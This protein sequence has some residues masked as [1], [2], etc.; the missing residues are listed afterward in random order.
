MNKYELTVVLN[1]K[2]E[3]EERAAAMEKINGY[4]TRFGGTVTGV[5]EWGKKRLAYEIQKMKEGFYY[6]I[7]FDGAST[8]P[9]DLEENVRIMEPVIRYLCVKQEA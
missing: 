8:T 9:N 1:A 3:D 4:I 5:D 2:L 6:F 7:K